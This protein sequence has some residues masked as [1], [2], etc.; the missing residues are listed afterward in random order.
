MDGDS[1]SAQDGTYDNITNFYLIVSCFP[2]KI[3]VF[4]RKGRVLCKVRLPM[5]FVRSPQII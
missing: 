2:E 3:N 1:E 5:C 4:F